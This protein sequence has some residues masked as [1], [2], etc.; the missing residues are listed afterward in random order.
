[1]TFYVET[2]EFAP[3]Y[4]KPTVEDITDDLLVQIGEAFGLP[5]WDVLDERVNLD[6]VRRLVADALAGGDR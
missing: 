4:R 5:S 3:L 6:E 1:M 2:G